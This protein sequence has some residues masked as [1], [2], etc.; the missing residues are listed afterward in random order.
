LT[1]NL[2]HQ[3]RTIFP[4]EVESQLANYCLDVARMG[5]GLSVRSV[6]DL[7]YELADKNRDK[8]KVPKGWDVNRSAGIEWF[9]GK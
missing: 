6:R 1:L 2:S 9:H 5:Y 3:S 7:A 8:I 4:D